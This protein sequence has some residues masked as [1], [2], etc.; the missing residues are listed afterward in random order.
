LIPCPKCGSPTDPNAATH[1]LCKNCSSE[2]SARER[3]KRN[4]VFCGVCGRVRIGGKWQS[5][6]SF[7]EFIQELQK[8]GNIV[9]RAKDRLVYEVIDSNKKTLIQYQLKKSLCM[10]CLIQ[11]NDSY[12]F[13]VKIRVEG[14]AMN[15]REAMYLIDSIRRTCLESLDQDFVYRFSKNKEGVDVLISSKKLAEQI[16][17]GLK[18]KFDGRLTQS[19]KLVSEKHDRTRVFKTTYSYRILSPSVGSVYRINNHLYEVVRVENGE[20]FLTAIKGRENMVFTKHELISMYKSNKVEVLT[21]QG[22]I[23]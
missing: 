2:P 20:V 11:K 4:I 3:K 19:F 1:N 7:D 5:N 16:V 6:L 15:P 23:L 22:S 21:Q 18:Q 13:E 9:S 12:L 10:N 14:R 8:Q 17:G